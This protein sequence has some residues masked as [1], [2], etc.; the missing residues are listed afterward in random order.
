MPGA[1]SSI[2]TISLSHTPANG[3]EGRAQGG[4][5]SAMAAANRLGSNP[6]QKAPVSRGR[7]RKM[8][9]DE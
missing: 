3:W 1:A 2:G 7:S 8:E 9:H 4:S 6:K 5:F